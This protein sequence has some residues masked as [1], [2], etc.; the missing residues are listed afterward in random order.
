MLKIWNTANRKIEEFKPITTGVVKMYACGP[1]VYQ[2]AHIGNI[3]S[4]TMEDVLRRVLENEGNKVEHVLNITDVGHLTDDADEGEDKLEKASAESHE[5]A[6]DIAERFTRLF[7]K[8]LMAMNILAPTKTPK[9]TEHIA[10]QISLIKILEEKGFTYKTSDGIYFDTSKYPDYGKFSGQALEEKEEGARVAANPE[11]KNPTDFALWKFSC[12]TNLKPETCNLKP[13]RQMEWESPWGVGFPGWHIECSAMAEKYLGQPFD[14]HAG[15]ID[16][17]PV[18]HENEIAQSVAAHGKPLANYWFHVE[19]LLVDGR[20]MSKSL[21]NF[22]TLDDLDEKGFDP[23]VL[24]YLFLGANYRQK[25]N[26]T[27]DALQA[28]KNALDKLRSVVRNWD[29]PSVGC[30]D[31]EAEFKAALNDDLNTSQALSIL[32][33]TV[34]S[35]YP[36]SAKAETVLAMD[37]VLGLGLVQYIHVPVEIPEDIKALMAERETARNEKDWAKSDRLRD[38]IIERGWTVED[39]ESGQK[40]IPKSTSSF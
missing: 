28:A 35:D 38:E 37:K 18:H 40:A 22:Y 21:T 10:E 24:R 5:S 26:F 12:P 29:K 8:D 31:L 2:R 16:H 15:G 3:R 11:K 17:I 33:K 25:Q 1:T 30:A 20:K 4:Y 36:T 32:W 27:W 14:I 23:I 39:T 6:K 9:A 19:F 7:F 34:D 13:T